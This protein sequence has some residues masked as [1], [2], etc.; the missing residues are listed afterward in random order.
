[1]KKNKSHH[2]REELAS[3]CAT[4]GALKNLEGLDNSYLARECP[5]HAPIVAVQH[6]YHVLQSHHSIATKGAMG[7]NQNRPSHSLLRR[8][9]EAPVR[10]RDSNGRMQ[11][12][13]ESSGFCFVYSHLHHAPIVAVQRV[14]H[15]RRQLCLVTL[16]ATGTRPGYSRRSLLH[17]G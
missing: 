1:M 9:R 10:S 5:R 13:M 17:H 3:S 11:H 6:Q 4:H 16:R 14:R 2:A 12:V 8:G 15:L 7:C